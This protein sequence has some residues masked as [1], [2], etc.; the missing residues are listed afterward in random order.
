MITFQVFDQLSSAVDEHEYRALMACS[1]NATLFNHWPWLV[2]WLNHCD[3]D[4]I[5][6]IVGRNQRQELVAFMGLRLD[7]EKLFGIPVQVARLLQYPWADRLGQM[8]HQDYLDKWDLVLDKLFQVIADEC[9]LM[10]WEQWHDSEDFRQRTLDWGRERSQSFFSMTTCQCPEYL[11]QGQTEEQVV[12][13]YPSKM[14]TDLKRR[15]KK[16]A[17]LDGVIEHVRPSPEQVESLYQQLKQV[18]SQSWKGDEGMGIF[19]HPTGSEFF[20]ELAPA[21]AAEGHLDLVLAYIDGKLASYKFGFYF[22]NR[23][24]DYSIAYLPEYSKLALGRILLDEIVL[25]AA[26]SGYEAVDA[27][28]V[29][30]YTRHLLLERSQKTI[31]HWRL[32]WFRRNLK[33]Q[34]IRFIVTVAKPIARRLRSRWQDW[35]QRKAG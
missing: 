25:E 12:A 34:A 30:P 4:R 5:L 29:G 11:L 35:Q 27:S 13:S 23:F 9:D 14:R 33:G 22:N 16:L 24:L 32:Y 28:R 15:R 6:F 26:R 18:E 8:L 17:K 2:T 31:P 21:L 7:R 10:I 19:N 1:P 3:A 20:A